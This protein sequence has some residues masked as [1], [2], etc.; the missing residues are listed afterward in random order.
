[1]KTIRSSNSPASYNGFIKDVG[2]K[3]NKEG[4]DSK[5]QGSLTQSKHSHL[6]R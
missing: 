5:E 2:K 6:K 1:M 3:I 4:E